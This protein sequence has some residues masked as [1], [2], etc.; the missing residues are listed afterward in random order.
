MSYIEK[1]LGIAERYSGPPAATKLVRDLAAALHEL[2]Q[3]RESSNRLIASQTTRLAQALA[4][5]DR[6]RR[7]ACTIEKRR[8]T[9]L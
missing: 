5:R 7:I 1:L 6:W 9:A 4:E 8:R 2:K 3:G